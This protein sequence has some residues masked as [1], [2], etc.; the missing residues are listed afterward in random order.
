M[1]I[2]TETLTLPTEDGVRLHVR[3]WMPSDAA[4][5]VVCIVHG[6]GEHGGR[7]AN[8]AAALVRAGLAVYAVDQRGHGLTP[9]KRGH[10]PSAERLALDAARFVGMAGARHPGLPLFLYGHSMGGNVALSC[11]IRC[12]PPIAGLILTSPWLRLAFDPSPARVRVGRIAALVWPKFTMATGLRGPLYRD[13]P[14]QSELDSRDPLLHNRISAAMFFAMREEGERSLREARRSL[15]APVLLL[16][17]TEDDVTSF[18]ASR[19][20][21]ETIR[22]QCEFVPWEGGLHEL[23]N[24]ADR[25]AVL[26]RIAGWIN[27]RI[28]AWSRQDGG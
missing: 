3:A 27:G 22:G 9:G 7:Y 19:E 24:D 11:A 15:R 6:M 10:A 14:L 16:H 2:V 28:E 20:L 8:V 21:A 18:A 5:G 26:E 17:G 4:R 13:N 23:H 25:E 1:D 12:R